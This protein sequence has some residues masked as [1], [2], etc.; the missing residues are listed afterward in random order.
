MPFSWFYTWLFMFRSLLTVF[1]LT[2][3]LVSQGL[4]DRPNRS[5]DP[6]LLDQNTAVQL[7][8]IDSYLELHTG[9]GRGYPIFHVL[10]QDET[11]FVHRRRTNW[12]YVSDRR[13]RSGWVRQEGLARTLAPTGL[14]AALPETKHGDFLAQQGRVGFSMGQQGNVE[15]AA[16]MAGYRLLSYAG[17]EAEYGQIFGKEI[18]GITYGISIMV[19]PIK[20]WSFTPFISKGFGWQEWQKKQKQQVGAN[21]TIDSQYEY[22]GLGINYYIGYSFVVRAEFR[23]VYLQGDNG[24]STNSAW[25]LGFSSFF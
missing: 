24:T 9:P 25:R 7:T 20:D 23:N 11:V 14:P 4:E 15:T 6:L 1:C 22:T 13:L 10:E 12:F 18:D 3:S 8:I 19:E 16:V 17:I 5:I 21:K 2:F